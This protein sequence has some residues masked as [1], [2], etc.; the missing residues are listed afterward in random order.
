MSTEGNYLS[1]REVIQSLC[2]LLLKCNTVSPPTDST[3]VKLT[4]LGLLEHQY[5]QG[6]VTVQQT[7][8]GGCCRFGSYAIPNILE[9]DCHPPGVW[10]AGPC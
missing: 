2:E 10:T 7:L 9:G 4:L 5:P 8:P 1:D 3:H 6:T